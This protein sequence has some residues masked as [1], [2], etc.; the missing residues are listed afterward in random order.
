M[1]AITVSEVLLR[2][3]TL[4]D[5][6]V[7]RGANARL[8]GGK[9]CGVFD[10][11]AAAYSMYGA[12]CAVLGPGLGADKALQGS[13]AWKLIALRAWDAMPQDCQVGVRMEHALH[14]L[15]DTIP[16]A[17]AAPLFREWA[18]DIEIMALGAWGAPGF[19]T[20]SEP[21]GK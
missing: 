13:A 1:T 18:A 19:A 9:A 12:L 17:Q 16:P 8:E 15:N 6:G 3:A 7:C 14:E 10:Q 21:V 20:S 2:A 11:R 4:L 5:K